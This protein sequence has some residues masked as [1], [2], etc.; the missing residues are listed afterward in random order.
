MKCLMDMSV[1]RVLVLCL[2]GVNVFTASATSVAPERDPARTTCL[3]YDDLVDPS[4][5][6]FNLGLY[7]GMWY[8]ASTNGKSESESKNARE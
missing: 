5:D 1:N 7:E 4:M 2:C 8:V 6:N 3:E